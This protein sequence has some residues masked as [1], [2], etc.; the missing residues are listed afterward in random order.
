MSIFITNLAFAGH[1]DVV[2]GSKLA[3]LTASLIAGVA[4][5]AW[6]TLL[7]RRGASAAPGARD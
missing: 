1:A 2:N 6:L 7:C 3:V 5:Y 4:G